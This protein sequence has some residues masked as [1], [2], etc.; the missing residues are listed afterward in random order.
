[1]SNTQTPND[2]RMKLTADDF[3]GMSGALA[4]LEEL[5]ETK[6]DSAIITREK[7]N[8]NRKAKAEAE[9]II[10]YLSGMFLKHGAELLGCWLIIKNEY[11][12]LCLSM[13]NTFARVATMCAQRDVARTRAQQA[14][15]QKAPP[16]DNAHVA[17]GCEKFEEPANVVPL[18][19][20]K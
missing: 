5:N 6:S 12:P 2:G 14:Q 7:E 9:G 13:Q 19:P 16:V 4:R 8:E 1:M 17:E 11:E 3:N 15:K 10:E 20:A 18:N